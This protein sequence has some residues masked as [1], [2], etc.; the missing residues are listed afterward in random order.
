MNYAHLQYEISLHLRCLTRSVIP[1]FLPLFFFFYCSTVPRLFLH[2]GC[3]SSWLCLVKA[4]SIPIYV[5]KWNAF[6]IKQAKFYTYLDFFSLFSTSNRISDCR[7]PALNPAS[8]CFFMAQLFSFL[9]FF[10]FLYMR[11][12]SS[13]SSGWFEPRPGLSSYEATLKFKVLML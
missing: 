7:L 2:E 5:S 11:G 8:H 4:I 10:F 13:L 12:K 6:F 9:F 1:P 3:L